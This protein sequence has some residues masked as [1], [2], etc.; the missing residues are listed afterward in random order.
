MK[1]MFFIKNILT[2][3]VFSLRLSIEDSVNLL[4]RY[5]EQIEKPN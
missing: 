1:Y 3:S 4:Q 2:T 5:N